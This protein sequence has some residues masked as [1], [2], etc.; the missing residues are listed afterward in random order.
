VKALA[1]GTDLRFRGAR[2]SRGEAVAEVDERLVHADDVVTDR[3][4]RAFHGTPLSLRLSHSE[5][6]IE[7]ALPGSVRERP[8]HDVTNY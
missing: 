7:H 8:Q 1:S 3:A 6:S 2:R 4:P 5:P